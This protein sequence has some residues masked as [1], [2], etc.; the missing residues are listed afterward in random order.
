MGPSGFLQALVLVLTLST[1]PS[2]F[3]VVDKTLE[4]DAKGE[5]VVDAVIAKI[6]SLFGKDYGFFKRL[7]YVDTRFDTKTIS[8]QMFTGGIWYNTEKMFNTTKIS[9]TLDTMY[10]KI[11]QLFGIKWRGEISWEDLRK[12]LYSALALHLY[13]FEKDPSTE[14]KGFPQTIA[15]QANYRKHNLGMDYIQYVQI[16]TGDEFV[17]LVTTFEEAKISC[18]GKMDLVVVLD[19]SGSVRSE[20]FEKSK[21]FVAKLFAQYS[22]DT[23]RLGFIVYATGVKVEL[24]LGSGNTAK[25]IQNIV[26]EAF[27]PSGGTNTNGAI[28]VALNLFKT[29]KPRPGVP[30][31]LA[32]FTDGESNK[33][34]LH[35]KG[36]VP[37]I[38][39]ARADG[40]TTYA[41][42]IGPLIILSE[43]MEIAQGQ[44]GRV[45]SLRDFNALLQFFRNLHQQTCGESQQPSFGQ[46]T[47]DTLKFNEHRLYRFT[48]GE[49]TR[50]F[51]IT[52]K[53]TQG[54]IEVYHGRNRGVNRAWYDGQLFDGEN[55]IEHPDLY[56]Q[57]DHNVR[58]DDEIISEFNI[59]KAYEDYE[60]VPD[61][62]YNSDDRT[63]TTSPQRFLFLYVL[64]LESINNYTILVEEVDLLPMTTTL[65]I[66]ITT[67]TA[68]TSP[69]TT[70][71]PFTTTE[72]PTTISIESTT[73][74]MTPAPSFFL[75]SSL[76]LFK[77]SSACNCAFVKWNVLMVLGVNFAFVL[78]S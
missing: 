46:G 74:A 14:Q 17:H 24:A 42:G 30:K 38:Q 56:K 76:G 49:V 1:L 69:T 41:V 33:G 50:S 73:F 53:T 77:S 68:P 62:F 45:F 75:D 37:D 12:P 4:D 20:N 21:N 9:K 15:E 59:D 19:G 35:D 31:V 65:P 7:A 6:G 10:R 58:R 66:I 67:T 23:T 34:G 63:A 3:C 25:N 32:V 22:I 16:Q 48:W 44:S 47:G 57:Q 55:Y 72:I 52:L 64:G 28:K 61:E 29:A 8:A 18:N 51:R 60:E 54:L 11:Y 71:S 70:T 39:Q 13:L 43:L 36:G 40:V 2:T 26:E 27:F 78:F 5:E